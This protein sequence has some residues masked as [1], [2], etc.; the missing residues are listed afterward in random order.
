MLQKQQWFQLTC[1]MIVVSAWP[2]FWADRL[3]LV[4]SIPTDTKPDD[5]RTI[6]TDAEEIVVAKESA[7]AQPKRRDTTGNSV[8]G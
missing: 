1:H 4:R 3:L 5:L 6:F 8:L 2:A 7:S